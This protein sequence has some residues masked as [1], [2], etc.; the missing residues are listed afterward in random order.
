M[1]LLPVMSLALAGAIGCGGGSTS[2][3]AHETQT[4]VV[5]GTLTLPGMNRGQPGSS[6]FKGDPC[7]PV[8]FKDLGPGADVVVKNQDGGTIATAQLGDGT[9]SAE[10]GPPYD[11]KGYNSKGP[12]AEPFTVTV[13]DG[14]TFYE[15]KVGADSRGS[16]TY[17]HDELAQAGWTVS[18]VAGP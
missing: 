11:D 5:K 8:G 6:L 4:H 18:L 10:G 3:G 9:A 1:R 7:L 14:A 16:K 15:F 13:P 2:D 17:S 12:C